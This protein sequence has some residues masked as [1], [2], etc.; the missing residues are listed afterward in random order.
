MACFIAPLAQAVVTTALR[1]KLKRT[2]DQAVVQSPWLAQLPKLEL[3]LWGGS[4]MLIVDHIING[5]VTWM[6]PFFTA[7]EQQDGWVTM[8]HE[9]LAVGFPMCAIVTAIYG[10]LVLQAS[11]QKAGA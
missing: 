6:Y 2:S 10:A 7:L 3:M 5:E 1:R 11:R 8:W 9:I 4:A